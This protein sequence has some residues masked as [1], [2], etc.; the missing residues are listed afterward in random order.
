MGKKGDRERLTVGN[1]GHSLHRSYRDQTERKEAKT[2]KMLP[3]DT[4]ISESDTYTAMSFGLGFR[5]G[6]LTSPSPV[7]MGGRQDKQALST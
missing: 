2:G 1:T 5:P 3:R 4:L 6:T 7:T